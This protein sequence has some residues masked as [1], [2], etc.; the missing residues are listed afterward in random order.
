MRLLPR[1][2][3]SAVLKGAEVAVLQVPGC[4]LQALVPDGVAPDAAAAVREV[5]DQRVSEHGQALIQ[6]RPPVQPPDPGA[7]A[8]QA[9]FRLRPLARAA[10]LVTEAALT[11]PGGFE[12]CVDAIPWHAPEDARQKRG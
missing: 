4:Q 5:A 12:R 9:H 11:I 6:V 1:D 8:L 3:Q 10:R 7:V 2:D